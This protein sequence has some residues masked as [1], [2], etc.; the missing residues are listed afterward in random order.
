METILST[1]ADNISTTKDTDTLTEYVRQALKRTITR[2]F[3]RDG[4]IMVISL[5]SKIEK[6]I[7]SGLKKADNKTYLNIDPEKITEIVD[8]VNEQIEKHKNMFTT[9]IILTS[10]VVR[11]HISRLLE[12]FIPN[13]AVLS[14]SEIENN[15]QILALGNVTVK[16]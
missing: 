16:D 15:V 8:G 10:S 2:T 11:I 12:Q 1:I 9:P 14:F 5:S 4:S 7:L 3:A 6:L 13:V